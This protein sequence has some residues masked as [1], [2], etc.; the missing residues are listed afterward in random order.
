MDKLNIFDGFNGKV[1]NL[2]SVDVSQFDQSLQF[3]H[4]L[5]KGPVEITIF[6]YLIYR[7]IGVFGWIGVGF[8]LVFVPIQ[9]KQT[10][11][12]LHFVN[13]LQ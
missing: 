12:F 4:L 7:E 6:G 11:H 2:M 3:I 8:I 1:I 9:S 10:F 5:W 13:L